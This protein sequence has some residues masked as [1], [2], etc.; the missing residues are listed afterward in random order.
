[1]AKRI[2]AIGGHIGDAELTSGAYM[3]SNFLEG[4]VNA[5]LALTAGEKGAPVGMDVPTYRIQKLRE[6]SDFMK[7]MNGQSF[8]FDYPDGELPDNEE[9]RQKIAEVIVSFKPDVI[10]THYSS[11][12]HK[13]HDRTHKMVLDAQFIAGVCGVNGV[14][15]FAK[16]YFAQ[17]WEDDTTFI[18]YYYVDVTSGFELYKKA[19]HTQWFV[20]NS[21]DFDYYDYYTSLLRTNGAIAMCKFAKCKYAQCF[22][23]L[24]RDKFIVTKEL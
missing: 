8:V 15:H 14:K 19:L 23:I 24:E 21:K 16:V 4:G 10:I 2:L 20:M 9:V 5:T 13:D 17:N 18:P 6:A 1:M 7:L 12:L 22:T 11:L 3:A